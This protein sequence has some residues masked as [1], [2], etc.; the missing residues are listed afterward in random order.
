MNDS[1][2]QRHDSSALSSITFPTPT[3]VLSRTASPRVTPR[4]LDFN[5]SVVDD[6]SHEWSNI[7]A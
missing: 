4:A 6:M 7:Q 5:T 2:N 1:R 3:G